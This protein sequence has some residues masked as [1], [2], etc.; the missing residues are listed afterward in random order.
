M[1]VRITNV[2]LV[3]ALFSGFYFAG[4]RVRF[5]IFAYDFTALVKRVSGVSVTVF[6]LV[7]E[8]GKDDG[9]RTPSK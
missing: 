1:L 2:Q 8:V 6:A 5:E 3:T 4:G 9:G 7:G